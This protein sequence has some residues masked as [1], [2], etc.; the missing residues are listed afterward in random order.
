MKTIGLVA[1]LIFSASSAFASDFDLP[2]L[3]YDQ[4]A[5]GSLPSAPAAGTKRQ[6]NLHFESSIDQGKQVKVAGMGRDGVVTPSS[7]VD[8]K[9]KI[10]NAPK[11]D[12]GILKSPDAKR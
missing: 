12:Q 9:L 3:K 8:F 4:R 10:L 5:P 2:S 7:D 1:V 11:V 6:E